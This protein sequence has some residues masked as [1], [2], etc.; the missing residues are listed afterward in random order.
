MDREIWTTGVAMLRQYIKDDLAIARAL[1]ERRW[2]DVRAAAI[3]ARADADP[4][5]AATDPVLYKTLRDAITK[6]N[7]RGYGGLDPDLLAKKIDGQ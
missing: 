4:R 1:K 5:L 3:V 7:L 6:F 2:S